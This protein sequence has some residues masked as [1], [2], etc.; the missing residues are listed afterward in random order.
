MRLFLFLCFFIIIGC[1]EQ[2]KL[3]LSEDVREQSDLDLFFGKL[4]SS[5]EAGAVDFESQKGGDGQ[6]VESAEII[7]ENLVENQESTQRTNPRAS[8]H[9]PE[10]P[11]YTQNLQAR[12][13]SSKKGK[14]NLKN[15]KRA[16]GSDLVGEES[17]AQ[18]EVES[19]KTVV[20]VPVSK[21]VDIV[22]VIDRTKFSRHTANSIHSKMNGFISPLH[23]L[24]WRIAFIDSHGRDDL[25]KP[26]SPLKYNG[27]TVINTNFIT[28]NTQFAD[29][30]FMD[31]LKDSQFNRCE[32]NLL[33]RTPL[34][35]PLESLAKLIKSPYQ[36]V[37]R[38]PATLAAVILTDDFDNDSGTIVN[39]RHVMDA[40]RVHHGE[41]KTLRVYSLSMDQGICSDQKHLSQGDSAYHVGQLVQETGGMQFSLC[42]D[43]Y[44]PVAHRIAMD[45]MGEKIVDLDPQKNVAKLN[46]L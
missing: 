39:A 34:E 27:N 29:K 24:E 26:F 20:D 5:D 35:K 22:F 40:L 32:G 46:Q 8:S 36:G 45:Q 43:S 38:E 10:S 44:V 33:C 12:L 30:V 7:E 11:E 2:V 17:V 31:T 1:S 4:N 28:K 3:N 18:P 14:K 6:S 15:A 41:E 23:E 13:N 16:S 21:D 42:A 37:I 25:H 9:Q 19:E